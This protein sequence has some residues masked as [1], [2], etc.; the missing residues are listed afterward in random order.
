MR[1]NR[2]PARR[3]PSSYAPFLS[4]KSPPRAQS[5]VHVDH[6]ATIHPTPADPG[7]PPFR[8]RCTDRNRLPHR[9]PSQATRSREP[10]RHRIVQRQHRLDGTGFPTGRKSCVRKQQIR[11]Q[12]P[13]MH[14]QRRQ[15]PQQFLNRRSDPYT[16]KPQRNVAELKLRP[17]R[18][19]CQFVKLAG[20]KDNELM[21]IGDPRQMRQQLFEIDFAAA[22]RGRGVNYNPHLNET[23]RVPAHRRP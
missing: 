18:R 21:A 17:R 11:F 7:L 12:P 16:R 2:P 23:R 20:V 13:Q 22:D 19:Q 1:P 14:R 3:P 15:P 4:T 10:R 8:Q 5:L 6:R 9:R